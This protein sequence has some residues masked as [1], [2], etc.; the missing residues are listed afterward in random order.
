MWNIDDT[1]HID[2]VE[3]TA[4]YTL[5]EIYKMK[6]RQRKNWYS[7]KKEEKNNYNKKA[8]SKYKALQ[9]RIKLFLSS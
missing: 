6:I 2:S 3:F 7:T 5:Q 1:I 8:L 9:L 4:T